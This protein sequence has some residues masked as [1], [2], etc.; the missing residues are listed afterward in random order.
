MC[1]ALC[2]RVSGVC[3]CACVCVCLYV[4]VCVCVCVC[5]LFR[6][7][8][9]CVFCVSSCAHTHT[10]TPRITLK[11]ATDHRVGYAYVRYIIT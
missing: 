9:F 1:V 8:V 2:A 5:V 6:A 7:P 3:A 11:I 4:F 10:T